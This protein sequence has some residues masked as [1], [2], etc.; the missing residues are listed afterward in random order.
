MKKFFSSGD[1]RIINP[2]NILHMPAININQRN[3]RS[4]SPLKEIIKENYN[5]DLKKP[6]LMI[7]NK[8]T[9]DVF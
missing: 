5:T 7:N 4:N 6:Y 9:I 3:L 2:L 1:D 8:P